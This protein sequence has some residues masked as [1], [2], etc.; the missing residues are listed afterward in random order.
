V[1]IAERMLERKEWPAKE[2]RKQQEKAGNAGKMK[3]K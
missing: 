2:K 1:E 3:E